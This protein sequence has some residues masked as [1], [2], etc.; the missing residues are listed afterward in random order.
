MTPDAVELRSRLD[1]FESDELVEKIRKGH[2]TQE[3]DVLAREILR[4]RRVNVPLSVE[5]QEKKHF[6]TEETRAKDLWRSGWLYLLHLV[7]GFT[8]VAAISFVLRGALPYMAAMFVGYFI[9]RNMTRK[10]IAR[11]NV[12]HREKVL[13]LR[14][15]G[16]I[17]FF[18][19]AVL[20][21]LSRGI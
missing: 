21:A 11:E 9:S 10:Y 1:T 4:E 17:L 12:E 20:H 6:Q 18:L 13:T 19:Q 2:L 14:L 16:I 8:A 3:A 5:L 7:A 15:V